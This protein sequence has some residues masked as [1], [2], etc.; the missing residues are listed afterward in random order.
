MTPSGMELL[1]WQ[2]KLSANKKIRQLNFILGCQKFVRVDRMKYI[3]VRI[4]SKMNRRGLNR[5]AEK[6]DNV[7]DKGGCGEHIKSEI[8]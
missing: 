7:R 2:L 1:K 3:M 6:V 8:L 5:K 4:V